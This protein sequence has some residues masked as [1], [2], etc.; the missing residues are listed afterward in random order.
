MRVNGESIYGT[1]ASPFHSLAWGRCT[2]KEIPGGVRLYLHVF[3]LPENHS[4]EVPGIL[5]EPVKAYLLADANHNPLKVTYS[6]DALLISLPAEM[7]D[8]TNTV[9]VLDLK[10]KLDLTEPP[11]ILSDFDSFVDRLQVTL[12]TNRENVQIHY[13]TDKTDP[14]IHSPVY[15]GTLIIRNPVTISARCFRDGK[16]VSGISQK[17]FNQSVPLP[18]V[19]VTKPL[20]GITYNYYEGNWDSIPDFKQLKAVKTGVLNNFSLDPKA[21]KEY[22]G[23][24]F[25]GYIMVPATDIYSFYTSS[26]DG[27]ALWIDGKK[28]ADNDGLHGMKEVGAEVG[29][30]QGYHAIRVDYFNKT[31]SD[32]LTVSI[33][34]PAIKKQ[35]V[36]AGMLFH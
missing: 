36:P 9:V 8:T 17:H 33:H 7:P 3:D 11:E 14:G 1:Q 5:N 2:R 34:S 12:K 6:E 27:S 23:F 25:R 31:G 32:G 4:L 21:A 24:S 22:Y 30:A 20:P 10:G 28:V 29:L 19:E 35:A 18:T 16:P 13:T 15:S 26:D